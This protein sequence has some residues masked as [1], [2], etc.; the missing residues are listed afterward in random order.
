MDI[1]T[2][3]QP[4]KIF[5]A[6]EVSSNILLDVLLNDSISLFED[7]ILSRDFSIETIK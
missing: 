2:K 6:G 4:Y 3:K 1:Y 7:P 5:V